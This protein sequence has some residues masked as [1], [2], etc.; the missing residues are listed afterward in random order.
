MMNN[1]LKECPFC[2]SNATLAI[3]H[4]YIFVTCI[5]CGASSARYKRDDMSNEQKCID[6]WN[7]RYYEKN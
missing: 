6:N 2:G 5:K 4:D 3:E 1:S 7:E